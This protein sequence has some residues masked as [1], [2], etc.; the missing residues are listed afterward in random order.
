MP[1]AFLCFLLVILLLEM[2]PQCSTEVLP[3]VPKC[4]TAVMYLTEK[5]H[6]L[7]KLHSG[8]SYSALGCGLNVNK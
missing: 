2:A 4:K 1:F 6:V 5:M 8:M 3:S 7:G